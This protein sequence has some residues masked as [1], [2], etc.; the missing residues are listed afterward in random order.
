MNKQF[1]RFSLHNATR[2]R[3]SSLYSA[4]KVS[5]LLS[6]RVAAH[7]PIHVD[8]KLYQL[9][10]SLNQFD[11]KCNVTEYDQQKLF[12]IFGLARFVSLLEK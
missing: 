7:H 8:E 6:E 10:A 1:K 2:R 3:F 9:K 12:T 11:M 5:I 4:R